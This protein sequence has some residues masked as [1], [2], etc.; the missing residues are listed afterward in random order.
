MRHR[1]AQ[2]TYPNPK[3]VALTDS[4]LV[5]LQS[6]VYNAAFVTK[7]AVGSYSTISPLPI[8]GGIFSVALSVGSRLPGVTWHS[9]L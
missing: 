8:I 7:Y 9:T 6:G 4:Y 2:A 1:I 5:L 3:R